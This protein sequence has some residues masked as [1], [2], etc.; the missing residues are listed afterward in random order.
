MKR[1]FKVSTSYGFCGTEEE[2]ILVTESDGV[3]EDY[4]FK[5]EWQAMLDMLSCNVEEIDASELDG[6][7]MEY[8]EE[9]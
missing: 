2:R 7:D 6:Y 5:E 4:I 8:A 3:D 9:I 1:Y